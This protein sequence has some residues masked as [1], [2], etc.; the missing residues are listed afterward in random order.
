[1]KKSVK[2]RSYDVS[3]RREAAEATRQSI[4]DAARQLFLEKGYAAATMPKIAQAAGIA[5]DTVYAAVGKKPALF[6]LLLEIAIS[7]SDGPVPAEERSYVQAIRDEANAARKLQI[8]ADAL[9]NMQPRLAP[10]IALLQQAAALDPELEE[11]WKSI[12]GRRAA[13]MRLLAQDLSATGQLRADLSLEKVA[14]ILWSMNA[15]EYYL[16]LTSQ[17]GWSPQEFAAWLAD[18]WA[19]LLLKP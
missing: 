13:N 14:D 17:R 12:A 6:R 1:L 3:S 5:L 11:L 9:G 10:L 16:L 2:K 7:G 18:A 15:P 19:R 4:L 8:Y